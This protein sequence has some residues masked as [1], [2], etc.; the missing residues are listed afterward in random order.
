[1]GISDKVLSFGQNKVL[2][3]HQG[4]VIDLSWSSDSK[5][6]VSGGMDFKVMVWNV[7]K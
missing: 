3:G 2:T 5:Y 1:M 7:E 4:E 6:L